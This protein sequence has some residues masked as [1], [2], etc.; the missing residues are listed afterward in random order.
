MGAKGDYAQPYIKVSGL[1]LQSLWTDF[2]EQVCGV[3]KNV[4]GTEIPRLIHQPV[5]KNS[6]D[7]GF[8]ECLSF[9]GKGIK[10]AIYFIIL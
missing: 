10:G 2:W 5:V 4:H 9:S 7:G 8:M 1:V 6:S 3:C